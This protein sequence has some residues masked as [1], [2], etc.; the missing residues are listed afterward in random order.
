[1]E[2]ESLLESDGSILAKRLRQCSRGG[3]DLKASWQVDLQPSECGA[4]ARAECR[5]VPRISSWVIGSVI[6]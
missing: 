1:M 5:M 4:K 3:V 2:V 6:T